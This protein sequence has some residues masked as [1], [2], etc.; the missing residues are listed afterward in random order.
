MMFGNKMNKIARC[1]KKQHA[2]PVVKLT[3]NKNKDIALAA[4]AALGKIGGE[5]VYNA[6]ITLLRHGD[7]AMRQTA[8]RALGE[9]REGKAK[10]HLMHMEKTEPDAQ[11]L[12]AIRATVG[13]LQNKD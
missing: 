3:E 4:V 7:A 8:V 13:K 2:A 9:L 5:E 11:V 12:S 6:L 1:V 10:V